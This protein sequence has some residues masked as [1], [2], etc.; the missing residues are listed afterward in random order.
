MGIRTQLRSSLRSGISGAIL[1][2]AVGLL[3]WGAPWGEGD[4]RLGDL[5]LRASYDLPV[6]VSPGVRPGDVTI[7]NMDEEAHQ[8]LGQTWGQM[9]DRSL[10][11]RFLEQLREDQCK[12]VVF[13]V[14][15][16]DPGPPGTEEADAA[17]ARALKEHGHVVLA[18]EILNREDLPSGDHPGLVGSTVRPPHDRFR[19]AVGTNWGLVR[20][21]REGD[22]AIRRHYPGND[23]SPSLAWAAATMANAPVITNGGDRFAERWMRYYGPYG[24]LDNLSYHLALEKPP[25]FFRDKIVFIGGKPRTR[26][27][28]EE[29]DEFR[30]PFTWRY[31]EYA[32]GVEVEATMFLNLLRG[33]WLKRMSPGMEL[34]LLIFLGGLFGFGLGLVRP[35]LSGLIAV[36]AFVA[37]AFAAVVLFRKTGTWFSWMIIGGAQIPCAWIWSAVAY[38][39]RLAK[40]NTALVRRASEVRTTLG[41][42]ST[43]RP[44]TPAKEAQGMPVIPDHILLRRIGKGAFGEVWLARNAVGIFHA[45]KIVFQREFSSPD[46]YEREFRGIRKFMPVSLEHPGLVRVLHV[47]RND[48]DAYFFYIMELA[49]DQQ[50]GQG[51]EP[52]LY[53]AKSIETE[54]KKRQCFS[55]AECVQFGLRLSEAL[56]FLHASKLVHRDIKPA[57]LIFVKGHPKLADIGLVSDLRS[58]ETASTFLG[59]P[60]YIAPEGPGSAVADVFSLGK[61]LYVCWTGKYASDFPELPENLDEKADVPGLFQ[62]NEIVVKACENNPRRRYRSAAEL[63]AALLRLQQRLPGRQP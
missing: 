22:G 62:L 31:G 45:V 17:L 52:E 9:W 36:A 48:A 13:D 2:V 35:G 15:L 50:N 5:W 12:L 1:T 27:V 24:T 54:L 42:H 59:T 60:G 4:E 23:L 44:V 6:L 51:F 30:T 61:V 3:L 53:A 55:I 28:G 46:P 18:A 16:A 20:V 41:P 40:E 49:D 26:F 63:H 19:D 32:S 14:W 11:A 43:D 34:A 58:P 8:A 25:G 57:N 33:D 56:D 29:V 38:T 7:I 21:E 39:K 37:V 10:H 47:G